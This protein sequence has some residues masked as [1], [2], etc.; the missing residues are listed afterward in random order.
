M[1]N[2]FVVIAICAL[3]ASAAAQADMRPPLDP[4][5]LRPMADLN[6]GLGRD[7]HPELRP[8]EV[9]QASVPAGLKTKAP[10]AALTS[11]NPQLVDRTDAEYAAPGKDPDIEYF[12]P[13]NEGKKPDLSNMVA[14]VAFSGSVA[15][16]VKKFLRKNF[17][18]RAFLKNNS[19]IS[20]Q[21]ILCVWYEVE[22]LGTAN[23]NGSWSG[24]S[25]GR[26]WNSNYGSGSFSGNISAVTV[27]LTIVTPG[28]NPKEGEDAAV[29]STMTQ[30]G[31]S[32][33]SSSYSGRNGG[34]YYSSGGTDNPNVTIANAVSRCATQLLNR[35]WYNNQWLNPFTGGSVKTE[36]LPISR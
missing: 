2:V 29:A 6:T 9:P 15:T 11:D 21:T 1:K 17:G 34:G 19:C 35:R 26:N 27:H 13:E 5:T 7:V 14:G 28:Q 25:G 32:Y 31:T 22:D 23:T 24:Y 12:D 8:Y 4:A 16:D 10:D 30:S 33:G 20:D 3:A 36:W 18:V